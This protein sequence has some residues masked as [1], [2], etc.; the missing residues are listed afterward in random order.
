MEPILQPQRLTFFS[1]SCMFCC[2][3]G[4]LYTQY[5][6]IEDKMGYVACKTCIPAMESAV[7]HWKETCAFGAANYLTDRLIKVRRTL[8]D[9]QPGWRLDNP[10]IDVDKDGQERIH[11]YYELE[12]IGRWCLVKDILELNPRK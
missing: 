2:H 1:V 12:N 10:F 3:N 4:E 5:V 6:H 8:G 11:C 9:V 7:K